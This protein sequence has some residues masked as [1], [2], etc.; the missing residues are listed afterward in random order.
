MMSYGVA[1]RLHNCMK[2]LT[3]YVPQLVSTGTTHDTL[4]AT[5]HD[6]LGLSLPVAACAPMMLIDAPYSVHCICTTTR[7]L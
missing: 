3:Y 1:D 7:N 2:G 6:E 5:L 4:D